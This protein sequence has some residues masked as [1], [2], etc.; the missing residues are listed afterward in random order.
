[1]TQDGD[2]KRFWIPTWEK[3][4]GQKL[5]AAIASTLREVSEDVDTLFRLS[6]SDRKYSSVVDELGALTEAQKG[7]GVKTVLLAAYLAH[8]HGIMDALI[9][10]ANVLNSDT[11]SIASSAPS[12]R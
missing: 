11:D 2:L 7:S 4:S 5:P 12:P 1:M 9:A 6:E 10:A 8:R 3:N